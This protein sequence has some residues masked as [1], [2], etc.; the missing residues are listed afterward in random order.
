LLLLGIILG[1]F[2][3][4]I[5]FFPTRTPTPRLLIPSTSFLPPPPYPPSS[6]P[7]T[8][9][10]P[11][12]QLRKGQVVPKIVHYVYGLKEPD[13]KSHGSKDGVGEEFPYY[14]YLAVRSVMVNIKPEKIYL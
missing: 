9:P 12:A 11:R 2:L 8:P 14:A 7:P 3:R 6:F 1:S 4:P 10:I 5:S 13:G